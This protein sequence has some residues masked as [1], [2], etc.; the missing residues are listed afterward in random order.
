[1]CNPYFINVIYFFNNDNNITRIGSDGPR[2]T[3]ETKIMIQSLILNSEMTALLT[4]IKNQY[5]IYYRY[6]IN[7]YL[8]LSTGNIYL[9]YFYLYQNQ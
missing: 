5:L 3:F 9:N 7:L 8:Y 6:M 2:L 4:C 1:M